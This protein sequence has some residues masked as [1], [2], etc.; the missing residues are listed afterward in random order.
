[1]ISL[2]FIKWLV[3]VV[4]AVIAKFHY[5]VQ[6]QQQSVPSTTQNLQVL[7]GLSRPQILSVMEEW[8]TALGVDCNYCHQDRFETETVRKQVARLM[9]REYVVAL[10]RTDGR[11]VSCQDCH[12]GKAKL[13]GIRPFENGSTGGKTSAGAPVLRAMRVK[14]KAMGVL[15]WRASTKVQFLP[16]KHFMQEMQSYNQALSVN[17]NYCHKQ[18]D[19]EAETTHKQTARFMRKEFSAKFI[20]ANGQPVSCNDC[21]QGRKRPLLSFLSP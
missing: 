4:I 11:A 5:A 17:C 10:K 1:M 12:Q 2:Q 8:S 21:H 3:I 18:G 6:A 15:L 16:K 13:L 20:K 7:Q 9:Q 14:L 19:F